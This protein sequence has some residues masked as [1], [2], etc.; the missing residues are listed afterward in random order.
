M[1]RK[2][3]LPT[4]RTSLKPVQII[5]EMEQV[6]QLIEDNR[7]KEATRCKLSNQILQFRRNI[8]QNS[9]EKFIL[10]TFNRTKTFLKKHKDEIIVTD[11]DKG[12]KTVILYKA[13]YTDKMKKLLEDKSTYKTIRNDPTITL[14][15]K[16]TP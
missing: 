12:N 3:A 2:F 10:E 11:A 16:T 1:G 7:T 4:T 5:A 9:A 13:D 8:K 6:I 14:Q 15:R